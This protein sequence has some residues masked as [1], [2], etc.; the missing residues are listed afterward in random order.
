MVSQFLMNL[1]IF[2]PTF[3]DELHCTPS[4]LCVGI[5]TIIH[6]WVSKGRALWCRVY[7]KSLQLPESNCRTI[8]M[9]QFLYRYSFY[10]KAEVMFLFF[11]EIQGMYLL[12]SSEQSHLQIKSTGDTMQEVHIT[13]NLSFT[14]KKLQKQLQSFC[15]SAHL[16]ILCLVKRHFTAPLLELQLAHTF[17]FPKINACLGSCLPALSPAILNS[18]QMN[19]AICT[20]LL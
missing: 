5:Y 16:L 19:L 9:I 15:I 6:A 1:A 11:T 10:F 2:A 12:F 7:L 17:C 8:P 3:G 20:S 13:V 4:C 18:M 14:Y